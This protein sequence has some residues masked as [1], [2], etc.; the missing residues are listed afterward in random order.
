MTIT[1][2]SIIVLICL[3]VILVIGAL[4]YTKLIKPNTFAYTST[5]FYVKQIL[6]SKFKKFK[7]DKLIKEGYMDV[8][9]NLENTKFGNVPYLLYEE[10]IYLISNPLYWNIR[11]VKEENNNIICESKKK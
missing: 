1:S 9:W 11:E 8:S 2:I 10:S 5:S 3:G 6:K 4:I 7:K